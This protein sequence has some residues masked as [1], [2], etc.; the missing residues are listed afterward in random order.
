MKDAVLQGISAIPDPI[1]N[2]SAAV[3]LSIV[4][5]LVHDGWEMHPAAHHAVDDQAAG[6]LVWP[7]AEA[8]VRTRCPS[9]ILGSLS[10]CGGSNTISA[11]DTG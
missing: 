4:K 9:G 6:Q 7:A 8:C 5:T 1:S 10:I 2:C 3:N 11:S